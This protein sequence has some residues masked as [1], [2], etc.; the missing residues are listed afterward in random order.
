MERAAARG[1]LAEAVGREDSLELGVETV[2][3]EYRDREHHV[4]R[5]DAR[6]RVVR[7]AG[8]EAPIVRCWHGA[9]LGRQGLTKDSEEGGVTSGERGPADRHPPCTLL[10][11]RC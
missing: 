4:V 3:G 6:D 11:C 2:E 9:F 7:Q 8:E 5:H 1:Q 10:T